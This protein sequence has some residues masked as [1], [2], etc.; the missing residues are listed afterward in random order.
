M[1]KVY[2]THEKCISY[3]HSIIRQMHLDN[4]KPDYIIGLARGGLIPATYL[5]HYLDIPM[6]TLHVSL[7]D[8]RF[9]ESK[10]FMSIDAYNGKHILVVD[11]INDTGATLEHVKNNWRSDYNQSHWDEIVWHKSVKFAVLI[12]NQSSDFDVD[13]AGKEINKLDNPEWCVFPWEEWWSI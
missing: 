7:R 4:F 2:Y 10:S 8:H 12:N 13:Y 11:D 9:L 1:N 5:S 6:H 3:L